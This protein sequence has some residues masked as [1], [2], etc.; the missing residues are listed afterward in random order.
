[1]NFISVWLP[2]HFVWHCVI[3]EGTNPWACEAKVPEKESRSWRRPLLL[4]FIFFLEAGVGGSVW[5]ITKMNSDS[6]SL[7]QQL[8]KE[9]LKHLIA[10]LRPPPS[11]SVSPSTVVNPDLKDLISLRSVNQFFRWAVTEEIMEVI[12]LQN[13]YYYSLDIL[14]VLLER[15][16]SSITLK[17]SAQ[18][19]SEE[20]ILNK[21]TEQLSILFHNFGHKK[22]IR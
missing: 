3:W 18:K 5:I 19:Q 7:F 12:S 15:L 14:Q 8:P 10:F 4:I 21:A 6:Q 17:A 13:L 1:M 2:C 20:S 11:Q 16:Q 9:I 22:N